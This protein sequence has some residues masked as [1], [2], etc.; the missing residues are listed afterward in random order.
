M[1]NSPSRRVESTP[2]AVGA[3]SARLWS[4]HD[5]SEFLGVPFPTLYRWRYLGEGP[6]AVRLGK[7][8]RYDPRR[9]RAWFDDLVA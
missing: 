8:L 2:D 7:H 6:P 9:V 5:V 4:I 3:P 1:P